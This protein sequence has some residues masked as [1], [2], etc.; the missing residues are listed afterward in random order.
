MGNTV[1][2]LKSLSRSYGY[3]EGITYALKDFDLKPGKKEK[4]IIK[5]LAKVDLQMKTT[6]VEP[7]LLVESFLIR[8]SS[9]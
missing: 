7:W 6:K 2:E 5:E 4:Q 3:G 9:F 8:L 1:I